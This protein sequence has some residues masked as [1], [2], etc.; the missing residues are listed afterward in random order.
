MTGCFPDLWLCKNTAGDELSKTC[1][2]VA[3]PRKIHSLIHNLFNPLNFSGF[4]T[5]HTRFN[6]RIWLIL[7]T[8]SIC[9][10]CAI[11]AVKKSLFLLAAFT[12]CLSECKHTVLSVRHKAS[13]YIR[14]RVSTLSFQWDNTTSALFVS[15]RNNREQVTSARLPRDQSRVPSEQQTVTLSVSYRSRSGKI[16][17][18]STISHL[19][20]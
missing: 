18:H 10:L 17:D 16:N 9:R 20:L 14:R 15:Q 12:D 6:I 5:Y 3:W 11:I 8:K 13:L 1:S 7:S 4:Y 19:K 2:I